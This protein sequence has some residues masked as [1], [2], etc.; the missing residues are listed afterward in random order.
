MKLY[1]F[2]IANS[3][4]ELMSGDK[5]CRTRIFSSPTQRNVAAY[6]AYKDEYA[7]MDENEEIDRDYTPKAL[8]KS[9]F[10]KLFADNKPAVIQAYEYHVNVE[11]FEIDLLNACKAVVFQK[12]PHSEFLAL[13]P[14]D[15]V[16]IR[17][18]EDYYLSDILSKPTYNAD[19]DEPDME[20]ETSNGFVDEYSV[21]TDI[22]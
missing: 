19:A 21:Y 8:A 17:V 14:G 7:T 20:V 1:G 10:Y 6:E 12:I 15:K 2:T 13:Q 11:P 4:S 18:G 3:S 9:S 5:M 16:Y 22:K